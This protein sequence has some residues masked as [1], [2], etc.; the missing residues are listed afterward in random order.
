MDVYLAFLDDRHAD[1]EVRPFFHVAH[2]MR[3]VFKWREIYGNSYSWIDDD[4]W[5]KKGPWEYHCHA[6]V[7]EGPK[8]WIMRK[9]IQ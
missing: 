1:L 4:V 6:D 7:D 2:A 3:Q 9:E 8:M 5:Q